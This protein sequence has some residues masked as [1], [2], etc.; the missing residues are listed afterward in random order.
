VSAR[1]RQAFTAALGQLDGIDEARAEID[2]ILAL[3]G[4]QLARS[5][6]ASAAT[7]GCNLRAAATPARL[8]L[9]S[10]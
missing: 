1:R 5:R 9:A 2:G 6:I 3:P 7:I 8:I 4:T 10:M